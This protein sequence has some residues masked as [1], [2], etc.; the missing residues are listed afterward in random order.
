MRFRWVP[1]DTKPNMIAENSLNRQF[2]G[3]GVNVRPLLELRGSVDNSIADVQPNSIV[4]QAE[5]VY[6]GNYLRRHMRLMMLQ[7]TANRFT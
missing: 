6:G 4:H 3:H 1:G 5:L 2:L 7:K